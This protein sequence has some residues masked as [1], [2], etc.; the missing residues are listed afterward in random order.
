M[1][2]EAILNYKGRC[3]VRCKDDFF[4]GNVL[5]PKIA[6]LHIDS[7]SENNFKTPNK[8]SVGLVGTI[9]ASRGSIFKPFKF[10]VKDSFFA[11]LD[12][13][14]AWLER[15]SSSNQKNSKK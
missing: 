2:T 4:Y 7:R 11:A 15:Q 12:L 3:L 14:S 6:F 10:S 5:E 13:A 1:E 9:A 8:V